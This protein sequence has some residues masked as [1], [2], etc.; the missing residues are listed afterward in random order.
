MGCDFSKEGT[1]LDLKGRKGLW[2]FRTVLKKGSELEGEN[3]H[4]ARKYIGGLLST[5]A[6]L[7]QAGKWCLCWGL[8]A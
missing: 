6:C 1:Y 5:V 8:S 2:L 4:S 3:D 7:R